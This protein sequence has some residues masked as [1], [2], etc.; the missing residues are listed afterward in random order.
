[1]SSPPSF[2]GLRLAVHEVEHAFKM[3]HIYGLKEWWRR[4]KVLSAPLLKD[5]GAYR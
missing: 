1:M 5:L 2:D 4:E 3:N